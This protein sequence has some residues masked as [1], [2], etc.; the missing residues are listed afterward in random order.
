MRDFSH[1]STSAR[2]I[3][4]AGLCD[5]WDILSPLLHICCY[6]RPFSRPQTAYGKFLSSLFSNLSKYNLWVS[7]FYQI[8][9]SQHY[10]VY[11]CCHCH[12]SPCWILTSI[13]YCYITFYTF[14]LSNLKQYVY[15]TCN[16]ILTGYYNVNIQD[17]VMCLY[18]PAHYLDIQ[19]Y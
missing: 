7:L 1:Q 5:L 13:L 18:S 8:F 6:I 15:K 10:Y 11:F 14:T 12:K 17:V 9:K 2:V 3:P 16:L 19:K 4:G